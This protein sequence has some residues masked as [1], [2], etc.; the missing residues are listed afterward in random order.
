LNQTGSKSAAE[1]GAIMVNVVLNQSDRIESIMPIVQSAMAS[2]IVCRLENMGYL[3]QFDSVSNDLMAQVLELLDGAQQCPVHPGF[4][5]I[6][7][8][9]FG[10]T[11]TLLL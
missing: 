3:G 5:L 11:R 2:G 6:G 1:K 9:E 10:V 8:D 4:R 7:V